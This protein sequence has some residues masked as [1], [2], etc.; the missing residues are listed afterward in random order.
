MG[1]RVASSGSGKNSGGSWQLGGRQR[2]WPLRAV[3]GM[4][5]PA[6]SGAG[7]LQLEPFGESVVDVPDRSMRHLDRPATPALPSA[8]MA[9]PGQI[10]HWR[11]NRC[12][13]RRDGT[14]MVGQRVRG[15]AGVPPDDQRDAQR[16]ILQSGLVLMICG[17]FQR[18]ILRGRCR[19]TLRASAADPR[20]SQQVVR[21]HHGS[22]VMAQVALRVGR[23]RSP[24]R[25]GRIAGGEIE[26][27]VLRLAL[28]R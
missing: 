26:P 5:W 14:P 27:V 2:P 7:G 17:S 16:R 25:H 4:N 13:T 22:S 1:I 10:D 6:C 18:V 21:Q 12:A 19:H 3:G 23:Q 28:R 11:P 24:H 9:G 20:P 8:R 15:P